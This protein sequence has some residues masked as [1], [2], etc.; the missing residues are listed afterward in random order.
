M[1]ED[2]VD[3]FDSNTHY[4][5]IFIYRRPN[6]RRDPTFQLPSRT[7]MG[8]HRRACSAYN[9]IPLASSQTDDTCC[10]FLRRTDCL[11]AISGDV[12]RGVRPQVM[13]M[14]KMYDG[15]RST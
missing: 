7:L 2:G 14:L 12:R 8:L 13:P 15:Y 10:T 9:K 5:F 4:S 1:D 3:V 11:S 6:R